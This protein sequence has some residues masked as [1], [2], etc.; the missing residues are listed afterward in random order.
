MHPE[1]AALY[2]KIDIYEEA[3]KIVLV[4]VDLEQ[5]R[6]AAR[7]GLFVGEH[8]VMGATNGKKKV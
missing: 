2:A 4:A 6:D 8:G 5:A 1:N 3:L 7:N